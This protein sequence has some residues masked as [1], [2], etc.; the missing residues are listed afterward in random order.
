MNFIGYILL[1]VACFFF[2]WEIYSFIKDI[3]ERKNKKKTKTSDK[4]D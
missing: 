4:N 2:G 1:A 3:K